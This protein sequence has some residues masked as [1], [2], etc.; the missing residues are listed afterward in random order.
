MKNIIIV[1]FLLVIFITLIIITIIPFILSLLWYWNNFFDL[2]DEYIDKIMEL[3][4]AT[5]NIPKK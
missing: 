5:L 4:E 3:T 2:F 1:I